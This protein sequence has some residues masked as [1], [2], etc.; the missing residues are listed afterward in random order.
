MVASDR[1]HHAREQLGPEPLRDLFSRPPKAPRPR[2]FAFLL[3][4]LAAGAAAFLAVFAGASSFA[5]VPPSP[6][7]PSSPRLP[8]SSRDRL[9]QRG[10][11]HH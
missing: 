5:G 11:I 1:T 4:G 7:F 10:Q 2:Y 6:P 3:D 8:R 9:G